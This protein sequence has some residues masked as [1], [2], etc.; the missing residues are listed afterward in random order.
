MNENKKEVKK[1]GIIG[2]IANL[3]LLILKFI[4]GMFFGSQ[5]LIADAVNSFGDIF[6]SAVTLIGGK[7]AEKPEDT[8]H[9]FGHGKAE[10]VATF[11]IGIFMIVVG[12]DTLYSS[13]IS[14]IQNKRF[15]LSYVLVCVPLITI[16]IKTLLYIY[17]KH[18]GKK[19]SSILI[20]ANA[21]DHRNDVF[22]STGVLIGIVFG[23]SGY[24]FVDGIIGAIISL[25]I[26]VTGIKIAIKAYDIL[27]DKCI[28]ANI[29]NEL[30]QQ[31]MK[32][33]GVNHIDEV[34]SKPTGDK[35]ILIVKISVEPNMTVLESH[36]IAGKIRYEMNKNEKI[37][38]TIV[39]IN[40][41]IKEDKEEK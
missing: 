16:F 20:E 19:K 32:L 14:A 23:Y 33:E 13:V 3:L 30:I 2:I 11:L 12:A 10:Y 5:G 8:D 26:V 21:D 17:T 4:G 22:L 31:I 29:S 41:D 25:I 40:P 1:V 24:Y 27:I 15:E 18:V 6:S 9:E 38:D 36:K 37:Y 35:H 39:H 34:K 7:I 28:D